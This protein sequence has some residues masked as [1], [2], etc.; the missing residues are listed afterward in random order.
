MRRGYGR[1]VADK[2]ERKKDQEST[3]T[4]CGE[5]LTILTK[6][7]ASTFASLESLYGL[8]GRSEPHDLP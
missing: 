4:T 3:S 5:L 6:E 2:L 8:A 1:L 7:Y